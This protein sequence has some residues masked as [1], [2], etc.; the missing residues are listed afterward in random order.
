MDLP[1]DSNRSAC[2]ALERELLEG[3]PLAR[4]MQLRVTH[5]CGQRLRLAAP[6]APNRN[7]KGC[8]F[9]GAIASLMTLAGWGL[10]WLWLH[11]AGLKADIYV[12]DCTVHYRAPL[13]AELE[14]EA[15]SEERE[16]FVADYRAAGRARVA[17]R[18]ELL[19]PDGRAVARMDAR[20]VALPPGQR[21]GS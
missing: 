6:L 9:G 18:L 5:Y 7:D 1:L 10:P 4:A 3:I 11:G 16:A 15:R 13:W 19:D 17:P 12:K 2:A 21:R 8:A 14:I 20:Y